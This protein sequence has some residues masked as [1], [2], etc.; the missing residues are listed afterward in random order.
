MERVARSRAVEL[1]YWPTRGARIV[2]VRDL[3]TGREWLVPPG[4]PETVS[5]GQSYTA[6][7]SVHGWDEMVPTIDACS[8]DGVELPDHGALWSV[9]WTEHAPRHVGGTAATARCRRTSLTLD[10]EIVPD[11]NG[12]VLH[13]RMTNRAT[14]PQPAYWA[15]HPFFAVSADA[16]V[17]GVQSR[18]AEVWL[19]ERLRGP[20]PWSAIEDLAAELPEGEFLKARVSGLGAAAV[21]LRDGDAA[22]TLAW[23]G[24]L[25]RHLAVVWDNRTFSD[26]R[27]IAIEP[28][29]A[30]GDT[31]LD[32][33]C[34]HLAPGAS[35]RW[36]LRVEP[37]AVR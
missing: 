6:G 5:F 7:R 11:G 35:A 26:H 19:P 17:E 32:P 9:P 1:R 34:P 2:S 4:D 31:P 33:D 30:R 3:A 25:V 23:T 21:T 14:T 12:L 10:R 16:R 24:D 28:M 13:Y 18:P 15:A 27:V 37:G 36:T 20:E 22:L 8:R 29:T